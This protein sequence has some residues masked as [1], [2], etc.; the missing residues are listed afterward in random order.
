VGTPNS[1]L[2]RCATRTADQQHPVDLLHAPLARRVDGLPGEL[3]RAVEQAAGE[4]LELLAGHRDVD[5]AAVVGDLDARL[6]TPREVPLRVLRREDQRLRTGAVVERVLGVGVGL[7]ERVREVDGQL[8]VPVGTAELVV[9]V[10][11]HDRDALLGELDHRDVE[12]ATAEV[13]DERD[14]LVRGG[15]GRRTVEPGEPVRQRCRDRLADDVDDGEA[16]VL[17]RELGGP[18]LLVTEV[19]RNRDDHVVDG[20]RRVQRGVVDQCLEDQAA[21][22][23]G[24]PR[25]AVADEP[26]VTLAHA[27]L[28]QRADIL[29]QGAG[30]YPGRLTGQIVVR[31]YEKDH[32]R[33]RGHLVEH[34]DDLGL[35]RCPDAGQTAVRGA[36]VDAVHGPRRLGSAPRHGETLACRRYGALNRVALASSLRS[37]GRRRSITPF[38]STGRV[39]PRR[40]PGYPQTVHRLIDL[41]LVLGTKRYQPA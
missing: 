34:R 19:R 11:G 14:L 32:A 7:R 41:A 30:L 27:P 6:R 10:D 26:P 17:A 21:D 28:D 29:R 16:G 22:R 35:P 1:S 9:A 33:K 20:R 15:P 36:E 38:C 25:L 40:R 31:A 37:V 24:R 3:H 4:R 39:G 23:G 18:S 8:L 5:L 12:R 2:S 13:V